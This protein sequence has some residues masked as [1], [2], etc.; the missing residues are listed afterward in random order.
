MFSKPQITENFP[1]LQVDGNV[2]SPIAVLMANIN[3]PI[4]ITNKNKAR[5]REGFVNS[6]QGAAARKNNTPARANN[7]KSLAVYKTMKIINA[8]AEMQIADNKNFISLNIIFL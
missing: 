1:A 6:T 7:W 3:T 4:E 2:T 5:A 8:A